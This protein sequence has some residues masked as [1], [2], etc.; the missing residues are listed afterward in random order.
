MIFDDREV[1]MEL[2]RE[3]R[4]SEVHLNME[5][6]RHEEYV[7]LKPKVKAFSGKG[8]VLGRYDISS[9]CFLFTAGVVNTVVASQCSVIFSNV[10]IFINQSQPEESHIVC[11]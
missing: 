4:G 9:L 8:H 1:P 3:A 5:D 6:H 10:L 11:S 7:P 2:V